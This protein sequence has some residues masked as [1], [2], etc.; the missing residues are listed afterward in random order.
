MKFKLF[1][2]IWPPPSPSRPLICRHHCPHAGKLQPLQ[3]VIVPG[4]PV[5]LPFSLPFPLF[6]LLFHPTYLI[7]A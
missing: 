3:T 6:L 1:R 2:T 7:G 4:S 5:S